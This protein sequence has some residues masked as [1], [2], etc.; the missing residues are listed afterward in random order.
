MYVCNGLCRPCLNVIVKRL[1][2]TDR[3]LE[4]EYGKYTDNR[5]DAYLQRYRTARE[6][7]SDL[8][9]KVRK[10]SSVQGLV[11]KPAPRIYLK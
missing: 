4:K 8:V 9:P 1:K 5:D 6:M 3:I 7:L 11:G 10:K 2:R